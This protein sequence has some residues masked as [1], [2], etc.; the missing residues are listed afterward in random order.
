MESIRFIC[1]KGQTEEADFRIEYYN[2]K[3]WNDLGYFVLYRL[4]AEPSIT[5]GKE[6][7]VGTIRIVSTTQTKGVSFTPE[8]HVIPLGETDALTRIT[9]GKTFNLLPDNCYSRI[10]ESTAKTLFVLLNPEQRK[11]FLESLHI[12]LDFDEFKSINEP[13]VYDA[14]YRQQKKKET[15]EKLFAPIRKYMLSEIDY[16]DLPSIK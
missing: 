10:N 4:F 5:K 2:P 16:R 11:V 13:V 1:S 9:G 3:N 8:G 12:C 14:L 15:I 7:L 6:I